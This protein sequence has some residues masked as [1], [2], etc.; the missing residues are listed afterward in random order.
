MGYA[1]NGTAN[2]FLYGVHS[3]TFVQFPLTIFAQYN[4]D[5]APA[6]NYYFCVSTSGTSSGDLGSAYLRNI[7]GGG[8]LKQ[9]VY[10]S[11]SA[12]ANIST[13]TAPTAGAWE[14][15]V[16][17]VANNS[18]SGNKYWDI[19]GSNTSTNARLGIAHDQV[20]IG[21]RYTNSS[22]GQCTGKVAECAIWDVL[23]SDAEVGQLTKMI[24]PMLVRPS[25]L[26]FYAPLIG[27]V[28]EL[29]NG[30]YLYDFG[31]GGIS[32]SDLHPRVYRKIG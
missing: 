19:G 21:T 10:A 23:L 8:P 9:L 4:M 7:G 16:G 25:N 15:G 17:T 3:S 2:G 11:A 22:S 18:T 5:S 1:F 28:V 6:Y 14:Y 24:S 27:N 20:S 30:I 12:N 31:G 32:A 26:V 13:S 29:V